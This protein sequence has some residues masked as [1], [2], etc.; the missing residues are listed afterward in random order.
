MA[1]YKKMQKIPFSL[2]LLCLIKNKNKIKYKFYKFAFLEF[3]LTSIHK[4]HNNAQMQLIII[5]NK[6]A[7]FMKL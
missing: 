3:F 1:A 6:I 2:L 5:C 7:S 4:D